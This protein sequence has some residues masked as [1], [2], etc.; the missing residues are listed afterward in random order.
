M[1]YNKKYKFSFSDLAKNYYITNILE[2]GY[3][4]DE[5]SIGYASS[6]PVELVYS[7]KDKRKYDKL[8]FGSKFTLRLQARNEGQFDEFLEVYDRNYRIDFNTE[9]ITNTIY[10]GSFEIT[11]IG[12]TA[13]RASYVEPSGDFD[14][15]YTSP[16]PGNEY[17]CNQ[18]KLRM[19]IAGVEVAYYETTDLIGD[20]SSEKALDILIAVLKSNDSSYSSEDTNGD[21][22]QNRIIKTDNYS[23]TDS[24]TIEKY[25]EVCESKDTG[26]YEEFSGSFGDGYTGDNIQLEVDEDGSVVTLADVTY[27]GQTKSEMI[28]QMIDKINAKTDYKAELDV[29][30][31]DK[32]NVEYVSG[33]ISNYTLQY[34][35]TGTGW[36]VTASGLTEET[37]EGLLKLWSGFVIPG[38]N[39]K[40]YYQ[41][42]YEMIIEATDGLA[43][44]DAINYDLKDGVISQIKA[45]AHILQ[46]T[47]LKLNIYSGA[48]IYEDDMDSTSDDDPLAQADFQNESKHGL[49]C[50]KVLEKIL[51]PQGCELKQSRGAWFITP[52]TESDSVTYRKFDFKGNQIKSDTTTIN[53]NHN[54]SDINDYKNNDYSVILDRSLK[55]TI[56]PANKS[57]L[58]KFNYGLKDQLLKDPTFLI[59]DTSGYLKYW[60]YKND[61]RYYQNED[62]L[63]QITAI[64]VTLLQDIIVIDDRVDFKL[65]FR[66]NFDIEISV[67]NQYWYDSGTWVDYPVQNTVFMFD[68]IGSLSYNLYI[69]NV[70]NSGS[71]N[72][73][74]V[75]LISNS[76][77]N[78][79]LK[80]IDLSPGRFVEKK[81]KSQKLYYSDIEARNEEKELNFALGDVPKTDWA[82]YMYLNTLL[83]NGLQTDSWGGEELIPRI[84]K[85]ITQ[86]ICQSYK[87]IEGKILTKGFVHNNHVLYSHF[88]SLYYKLAGGKYS[89][90]HNRFTGKWLEIKLS[91]PGNLVVEDKLFEGA[92]Q[93]NDLYNS[94]R[95]SYDGGGETEISGD[96][97]TKDEVLSL[98]A[99]EVIEFYGYKLDS[100]NEITLTHNSERK[101]V[102]IILSEGGVPIEGNN[103][104]KTYETQNKVTIKIFKPYAYDTKF[105]ARFL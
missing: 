2:N 82:P 93:G 20:M 13:A 53:I 26:W 77:S 91:D 3:T 103:Y 102:F 78:Q 15:H 7:G 63:L 38:F 6:N 36:D 16:G 79:V 21:T 12:T 50:L 48:N 58:Y 97:I 95:D 40:L 81:G 69:S 17:P 80:S 34:S 44:L 72:E 56:N 39:E 96:Y 92:P 27:T 37:T 49:S 33:S 85:T 70:P 30:N 10:T 24:I 4:G 1:A 67:N 88:D 45:I 54:L 35:T 83:Y 87:A 94:N 55:Q 25:Y 65:T 99:G 32:I 42:Y 101:N 90:R 9:G 100:N 47:G 61:G 104:A 84:A 29:N 31:S 23:F 57:L 52:L 51:Y 75:K 62:D 64:D 68:E 14:L 22:Y 8:V 86:G 43:D 19:F 66:G 98:I 105:I 60:D 28:T 46:K 73:L 5:S 89:V 11:S 76:D 18:V 59:F 71:S 41:T 74:R